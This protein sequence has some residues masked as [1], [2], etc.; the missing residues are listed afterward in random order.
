MKAA[1]LNLYFKSLQRSNIFVAI[2]SKSEQ[3][4]AQELNLKQDKMRVNF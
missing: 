2:I 4:A 1:P 3:A